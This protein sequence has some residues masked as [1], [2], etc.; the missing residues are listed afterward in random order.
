MAEDPPTPWP[1]P[2]SERP[3]DW[4]RDDPDWGEEG[5]T[6]DGQSCLMLILGGIAVAVAMVIT[7]VTLL[8]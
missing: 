1:P 5:W 8:R 6:E 2:D 7:Y 3:Y 4:A